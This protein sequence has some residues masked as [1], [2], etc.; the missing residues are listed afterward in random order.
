MP[1]IYMGLRDW[2][3]TEEKFRWV[4]KIFLAQEAGNRQRLGEYM[5]KYF[6]GCSV[7]NFSRYV[8]SVTAGDYSR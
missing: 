2:T 7:P 8:L 6:Y 1:N 3:N 5:G 4:T